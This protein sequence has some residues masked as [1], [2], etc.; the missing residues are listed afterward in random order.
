MLCRF[1]PEKKSYSGRPVPESRKYYNIFIISNNV[2]IMMSNEQ[3]Y[4]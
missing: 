3:K 1:T 4:Y 2:Y